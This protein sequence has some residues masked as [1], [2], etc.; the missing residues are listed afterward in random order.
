VHRS[1]SIV[2]RADCL[3]QHLHPLSSY[4]F[5]FLA[6]SCMRLVSC[7]RP[8]GCPVV[9]LIDIWRFT[10][11]APRSR[12]AFSTFVLFL[13]EDSKK[14]MFPFCW[15]NFL[16]SMVVTLRCSS[17]S[18]LLPITKNGN[19]SM[20]CGYDFVRNTCFQ[21]SRWSKLAGFVTS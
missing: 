2:Y 13:A 4:A 9:G 16:A 5:L 17:R 3:D 8:V 7:I 6:S 11:L 21:S 10:A 20:F 14:I 1:R 12:K 18:I 15:Q 19:V